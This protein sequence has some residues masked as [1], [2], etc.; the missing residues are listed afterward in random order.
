MSTPQLN[1]DKHVRGTPSS[2][3]PS[4][5]EKRRPA[6]PVYCKPLFGGVHQPREIW[7]DLETSALVE[8]LLLH[9]SGNKWIFEEDIAF[10]EQAVRHIK[11]RADSRVLRSG[12][13]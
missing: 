4:Q 7:T 13:S 3:M 6:A 2:Q 11:M 12:K 5:A 9:R 8:F 10:W 1:T